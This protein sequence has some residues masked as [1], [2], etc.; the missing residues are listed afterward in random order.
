M[1]SRSR[2]AKP[3]IGWDL[4]GIRFFP[5]LRKLVI[6]ERT[7]RLPPK[8]AKVLEMLARAAPNPATK[9]DLLDQIWARSFTGDSVVADAVKY[10]RKATNGE[11]RP[12]LIET[13]HKLGYRMAVT[14]IA[15]EES[16]WVAAGPESHPLITRSPGPRK[17]LHGVG[18]GLPLAALVLGV[19]L[20]LNNQAVEPEDPGRN[21]VQ[22]GPTGS[23]KAKLTEADIHYIRGAQHYGRY[24]PEDNQIAISLFTKT[25]EFDPNYVRAYSGLSNAYSMQAIKFGGDGG[26]VTRAEELA[27]Q[28]IALQPTDASGYK[29]LGLAQSYHGR[30]REAAHSYELAL[31]LHP[32]YVAAMVNLSGIRVTQG[33]I[34][35]ALPLLNRALQIAPGGVITRLNLGHAYN[36][37]GM[38]DL[39]RAWYDKGKA[40]APGSPADGIAALGFLLTRG[41]FGAARS[42]LRE[43]PEELALDAHLSYWRGMTDLYMGDAGT[44]A[45]NFK[46]AVAYTPTGSLLWLKSN[47]R[48]EI[49]RKLDGELTDDLVLDEIEILIDD[50]VS[51][52]AE[53]PVYHELKAMIA[54]ARDQV[55]VAIASLELAFELGWLAIHELEQDPALAAIREHPDIELLMARMIDRRNNLVS[56]FS[57]RHRSNSVASIQD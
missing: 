16:E 2:Q 13:L 8:P 1:N 43:Q 51:R 32:Q 17:R 31:Q 26:W 19:V 40:L 38:D 33:R 29:A 25:L 23:A 24:R 7:V 50:L 37:L 3:L 55:S 21:L 20:A 5:S 28:A 53:D 9:A 45:A 54:L 14:P 30:L 34:D 10:L 52:G 6:G 49:A 15:I 35:E 36:L 18:I 22:Q 41:D 57:M 47:V 46:L 39:A 12:A 48:H 11:S 44:A 4:A 42:L 27:R 56:R